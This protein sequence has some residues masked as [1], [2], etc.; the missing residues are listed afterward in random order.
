MRRRSFLASLAAAR[1]PSLAALPAFSQPRTSG[2]LKIT[3]VEI[4]RLEGRREA[5]VGRNRQYQA[6]PIH[7]YEEHRPKPYQDPPKEEKRIVPASALYLKIKTDQGL[8]GVYGPI[9]REAAIVVDQQLRNLLIGKDPLA[10]ETLWDLMHR[11]NRHSRHGHFMMGISAVDNTLWDLRGRYFQ[12]PVYKLLGGPTRGAVEAYASCLGYSLEPESVRA[13]S[14]Q[15]KNEG[16]RHEK[17]F[18]AYGP[19][20]GAE[21]M[22][23][24]VELVKNLREAVGDE[25]EL[26]FD[27]FMGWDLNY[28][29]AWATQAEKYRPFWIEEVFATEKIESFAQL[30]H[31]TSIP[32]ASGEHIYGRWE[33]WH[34]LKA[35]ALDVLQT[36][37]EWCGGVSELVK[38]CTVASL[39]DVRVIPHGHS[40]HTALHVVASQSPMTCPLVEYLITKM[41][42][43]HHFEKEPLGVA[44]G[45]IALPDRPGFGIDL[46]PAKVEKQTP[47]KWG[48]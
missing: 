24:N 4:W 20:S 32:V 46:D 12:A 16:F 30:R 41:S 29:L 33:A 47:V 23:K 44:G 48:G 19:G 9:D 25:V 42:S 37:P 18:L 28:A 27:A 2:R 11:S 8:E 21:G 10:V 34:Y 6:N 5:L 7:I 13:R 15:F 1:T 17:W 26:M 39:Y 35:D 14:V 3:G 22:W 38:I 43:Y 31:A 45:K 36:D 40:L